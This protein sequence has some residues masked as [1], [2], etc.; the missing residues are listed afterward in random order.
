MPFGFIYPTSSELR[1]IEQD[2]LPVLVQNDPI[3]DAFPITAVNENLLTWIAYDRFTGLQAVRG[4][5]GEASR[6]KQIGAKRWVM[7]P[8]VYG[9]FEPIDE[10]ELTTRRPIGEWSGT[11]DI[12]DL[13]RHRQDQLLTRE[14]DRIRTVIWTLLSY[15]M[16]SVITEAGTIVHT[17]RY[18]M[19]TAANTVPWH[20]S[21]TA[22]PLNDFRQVKLLARGHSVA[23]DVG[24][25]A[26]MNQTTF[27]LMVTNTNQNDL[28]GRR[29]SA[30]LSPLNMDEINKILLGE[31]LPQIKIMD[32]G[33]VD[34]A[35]IFHLFIPTGVTVLVGRRTNGARLG[36]YR[37]TRNANNPNM[38]PGSYVKVI[39]SET[40][41][42][43]VPRNIEVHRGHNGGPVMFYPNAVVVM[44]V[45]ATY[46][47]PAT[48]AVDPLNQPV[49]PTNTP[50]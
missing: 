49:A 28:A 46:F 20:T 5:N 15:G 14:I 29:V 38:E 25:I 41:G 13:V 26:Y 30:L 33:Y 12:T 10:M 1:E 35:G 2:L 44:T 39:D 21:A 34:D 4:L 37:M 9:E 36:E 11:V 31:N 17:D 50:F 8:G 48:N 40:T 42:H 16:F 3:F 32:D 27:N 19:Q 45:D 18:R 43:P 23:F 47:V 22:T 24:A 7:E 6:V